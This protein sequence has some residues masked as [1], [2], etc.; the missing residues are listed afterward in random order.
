MRHRAALFGIVVGSFMV[1]AA[2]AAP[3][4]AGYGA[5]W[6]QPA[7]PLPS[8]TR[9][10]ASGDG[11]FTVWSEVSPVEGE[12]SAPP[13]V[14]LWAQRFR[15]SDGTPSPAAPVALVTLPPDNALGRVATA[16]DAEGGL[17][18]AWK[19]ATTGETFTRR[20]TPALEPS[21]GALLLCRDGAPAASVLAGRTATPE[22]IAVDRSG[23]GYF[24]RLGVTPSPADGD[25][26]LNHVSG[27]GML[28]TAQ[29]GRHP[30]TGSVARLAVDASGRACALLLP[31]GRKHALLDRYDT[32][33]TG[34][35]SPVPLSERGSPAPKT[36]ST[37][38]G[39]FADGNAVVVAWRD[40]RGLRLQRVTSPATGR[41]K[42]LWRNAPSVRASTS[43]SIAADSRGGA[44]LVTVAGGAVVVRHFAANGSLL[45]GAAGRRL[46]TGLTEVSVA[47]ITSDRSGALWTGYRGVDPDTRVVHARLVRTEYFPVPSATSQ[48]DLGVDGCSRMEVAT[49]E[50]GGAFVGAERGPGA[51]SGVVVKRIGLPGTAFSCSV[52]SRL[53]ASS[54][55]WSYTVDYGKKVTLA[56]YAVDHGSPGV[57]SGAEL[58]FL[59]AGQTTWSRGP[60]ITLAGGGFWT[61]TATPLVSG[62]WRAVGPST[63]DWSGSQVVKIG[64]RPAVTARLGYKIIR[65]WLYFYVKGSVKPR[66]ANQPVMLKKVSGTAFKTIRSRT[67]RDS[68]FYFQWQPALKGRVKYALQVVLPARTDRLE[69][70][71]RTLKASVTP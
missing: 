32:G 57:W 12:P 20:Y 66:S 6:T 71:S 37:A 62:S 36:A 30:T 27:T 70:R 68:T 14:T 5:L 25:T 28:A 43:A 69:G 19:N 64:V 15:R 67:R 1:L 41:P 35:A 3:A 40:S 60:A 54:G 58:Q 9:V 44:Y 4:Q 21:Y 18:V 47:G 8:G 29:P 46:A 10:V 17:V 31:P 33:L 38:V 45:T 63:G 53:G 22:E 52:Q 50:L 49:D 48:V 11:V 39:A 7:T 55:A 56:G 16:S 59:P 13:V 23:T 51:T 26:L 42:R 24:V 61:G 65:G 2:V 34:L